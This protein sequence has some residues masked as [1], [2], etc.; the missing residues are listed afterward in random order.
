[1]LKTIQGS[2][3]NFS[4]IGQGCMGLGGEF[5]RDESRDRQDI[6]AIRFGIDLGLTFIDTAEVYAD[7]HSE[8]LVGKATKNQR[9]EVFIATKFSPQNSSYERVIRAAENSLRRLDTD[10]IDLYQAHWPNPRID[11]QETIRALQDLVAQGKVRFIGLSNFSKNEMKS[12]QECLNDETIFSNQ[13][14]YNLFDRFVEEDIAPYCHS[15]GVKVIAYSPLDKAKETKGPGGELLTSLSK[16]YQCSQAQLV[17]NWLVNQ[18]KTVPIPKASN[19]LHIKQNAKSLDF[20]IE[21]SDLD[22][23]D[24]MFPSS[25]KLVDPR[26]IKVSLDGEGNRM[27]YQTIK[28][29]LQNELGHSPSPRELADFILKG[30]PIKPVRL[31]EYKGLDPEFEYELIEGRV[32][33]WGW[34][35]AYDWQKH[36]PAY[37]RMI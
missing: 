4:R 11:I 2:P 35:I 13:V 32:R 27:A 23:I 6:E 12:A 37:I 25:P 36:V 3:N 20:T 9:E 26:K 1:M 22:Q 10:Y 33:Y 7:G 34:V 30:D 17:L 8:E 29:A 5:S 19:P 15:S 21:Q 28:E 14:E 31:R 24:L 18:R 16:K